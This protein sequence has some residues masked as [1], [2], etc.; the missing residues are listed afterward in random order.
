MRNFGNVVDFPDLKARSRSLGRE[1]AFREARTNEYYIGIWL[2]TYPKKAYRMWKLSPRAQRGTLPS[3]F[4]L[5]PL[6]RDRVLFGGE[7]T[8]RGRFFAE[9]L[10]ASATFSIWVASMETLRAFDANRPD[11]EEITSGDL[12]VF[13]FVPA[14]K[15]GRL[16]VTPERVFLRNRTQVG[17]QLLTV[18]LLI[19]DSYR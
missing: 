12:S 15:S 14:E 3:V 4:C 5:P 1:G 13:L 6:K 19:Y 17:K 18:C 11:P 9:S 7:F 2:L 8:L 16:G 10:S